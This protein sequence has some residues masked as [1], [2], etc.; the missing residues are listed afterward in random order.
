MESMGGLVL[1]PPG[2]PAKLPPSPLGPSSGAEQE[3]TSQTP[4]PRPPG[5]YKG[6]GLCHPGLQGASSVTCPISCVR[7]CNSSGAVTTVPRL[8]EWPAHFLLF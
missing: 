3:V 2:M 8:S 1:G 7:P 6:C 5:D 4:L